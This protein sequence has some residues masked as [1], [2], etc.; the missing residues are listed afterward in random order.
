MREDVLYFEIVAMFQKIS[1][2]F[3]PVLE[4]HV[5]FARVFLLCRQAVFGLT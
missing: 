3:A 2:K 4:V 5:L 1:I